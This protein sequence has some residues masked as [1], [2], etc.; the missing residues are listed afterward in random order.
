MRSQITRPTSRPSVADAFPSGDA[1][2]A[3]CA[4]PWSWT[5]G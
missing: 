4:V 1:L 3:P 2:A 5:S